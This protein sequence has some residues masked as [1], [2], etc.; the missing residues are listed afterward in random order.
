MKILIENN[1]Q[2]IDDSKLLFSFFFFWENCF[3]LQ[4]QNNF[5]FHLYA[6]LNNKSNYNAL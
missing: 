3:C 1:G 2:E 4:E 6:M 5:A